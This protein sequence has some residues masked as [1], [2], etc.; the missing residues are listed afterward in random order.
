MVAMLGRGVYTFAEAA[1]LTGLKTARV[2]EWFRGCPDGSSRRP[3]LRSDYA[4]VDKDYAIS[5]HDLIDVYVAGQLREHG[6]SL[7]TVR[8]AYGWMQTDL[9]TPHPFCRQ[10]L[11]S[12]GKEIFMRGLDAD[13]QPGTSGKNKAGGK[14]PTRSQRKAAKP[15]ADEMQN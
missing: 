13:G 6:V 2:K 7:Q 11:L 10:E 8:K 4:P 1:K 5:F 3:V 12:D 9:A 15:P 14:K